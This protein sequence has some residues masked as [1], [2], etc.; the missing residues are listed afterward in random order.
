MYRAARSGADG[1]SPARSQSEDDLPLVMR[2]VAEALDAQGT[3]LTMHPMDG[4]EP[5]VLFADE[6]AGMDARVLDE[7]RRCGVLACGADS[8]AF[9]WTQCSV[10]AGCREIL[11]IPIER[12]P[13]HSRLVISAV[14]SDVTPDRRR[15]AE[16]VYYSRRPFAVGYFRLWQ[17][18]RRRTKEIAALKAALDVTDLGVLLIDRQGAVVHAN[19][20]GQQLLQQG[21]DLRLRGNTLVATR[22]A[23]GLRL[24]VALN[25]VFAANADGCDAE[26][27]HAP[28]FAI[29]QA[30]GQHLVLAISPAEQRAEEPTDVAAILYL[31]DPAFDAEAA[32]QP[33][34]K[35]YQLSPAESRLAG[36]LVT[37]MPL[38]LVAERMRIK[39]QTARA[40]L[41]QI[42][43][44]TAT[45]RQADL[46]R[47][48]LSSV[49]RMSQRI[50]PEVM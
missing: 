17:L 11:T 44:K 6:A 37:G 35:L 30:S 36:L 1:R 39:E 49:L 4:S 22:L 14:F 33:T 23:D 20:A 25:H 43:V 48:M 9:G 13:G 41:K 2:E 50:I 29:S 7:L 42:F 24:Q 16:L 32:L 27:R 28:T 8:D 15:A 3:I 26:A 10:D 12:V 46:V 40:Y 31:L 45:N 19:H 5:M 21:D 38:A 18:E 34:C 47:L